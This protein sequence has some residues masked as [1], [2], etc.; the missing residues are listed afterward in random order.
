MERHRQDREVAIHTN[1]VG[2]AHSVVRKRLA[3]LA[4]VLFRGHPK[5][6]LFRHDYLMYPGEESREEEGTGECKAEGRA[7]SEPSSFHGKVSFGVKFPFL[8]SFLSGP[9]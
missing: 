6:M 9:Q 1:C 4:N 7:L 8:L 3:G 2:V 5:R